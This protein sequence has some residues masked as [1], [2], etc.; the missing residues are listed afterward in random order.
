MSEPR[1]ILFRGQ[2]RRYGQ[3]VRM[4]GSPVESNWVYGGVFA[5]S[6][7]GDFAVIYT[8]DPVEKFPVYRDTVGQ[9]T[10][11]L[12]KNGKRIFEGDIIRTHYANA[13]NADFVEQV[14]FHNGQF[15]GMYEKGT[16]KAFAALPDGVPHVPGDKSVYMDWCEVIGNVYDNPDLLEVTGDGT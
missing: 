10:G 1:E 3:K 4:D 16:V 5:P 14:V 6:E 2:T 15:C 11:L 8:Y 7:T 13:E 9:Y 12:D